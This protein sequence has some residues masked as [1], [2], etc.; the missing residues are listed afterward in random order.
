[1]AKLSWFLVPVTFMCWWKAL[2]LHKDA[3][4]TVTASESVSGKM[5]SFPKPRH[6]HSTDYENGQTTENLFYF[7]Q[8]SDIHTSVHNKYGGINNLRLFLNNTLS[9]ISPE[10]VL[11]TGDITDAKDA[12]KVGSQQLLEEWKM[13]YEV[14]DEFGILTREPKFWFDQRGNHDCFNVPSFHSDNNLFRKYSSVKSEQYSFMVEKTFG[15]YSFISVDACPISGPSRP[16]NFFGYLDRVD[17]DHL[18]QKVLQFSLQSNHTFVMAHYPIKMILT[19]VSS[20]GVSFPDLASHFSVFLS[21]H[22]HKLVAGLGNIMHAHHEEN[23]LEL[24]L[25]DLKTHGSYRII[26]VDHD[27][28]SF[29]DTSVLKKGSK[30]DLNTDPVVLITNP[31]DARYFITKH[32]PVS[33]IASSTHIRVLIFG[34]VQS[35]KCYIDGRLFSDTFQKATGFSQ[36]VPLYLI[37]WNPSFFKGEQHNLVIEA[38]DSQGKVGS[39]Q[40][41]FRTDGVLEPLLVGPGKYIILTR[42]EYW[43]K[44][45]FVVSYLIITLFLLLIPKLY[46]SVL[47]RSRRYHRWRLEYSKKLVDMDR[48]VAVQ[49]APKTTA[50]GRAKRLYQLFILKLRLVYLDFKYFVHA[51]IFR[52]VTLT[53]LPETFY[54]LYFYSL[55]IVVGPFFIGELIPDASV[56]KMH[57]PWY[58]K[59]GFFY[60]VGIYVE[61]NWL[62]L[63]DTWLFGLF[64]LLYMLG[65]LIVYLS[66]CITPPEQLYAPKI[67]A[68]QEANCFYIPPIHN[69]RKYPLHRRYFV[70]LIVGFFVF[71]QIINVFFLC[72]YY[73]PVAMTFSPGK[74]WMV[75]WSCYA[76]YKHRWSA[77]GLEIDLLI[78]DEDEEDGDWLRYLLRTQIEKVKRRRSLSSIRAQSEDEREKEFQERAQTTSFQMPST[79]RHHQ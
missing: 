55:Y 74:T 62:P 52:L 72:L 59:F 53:S 66:F 10:F 24:E 78:D 37:P 42:Y 46:S 20:T 64:E 31:K 38:T 73:G 11:A 3:T 45:V 29:I 9:K 43:F 2:R 63:L 36:E 34:V 51:T 77:Q 27:L 35:I 57:L 26:A 25:S 30:A 28:I 65:P 32:E 16:F 69:R 6:S 70:R 7:I 68:K 39:H 18:E 75:A 23:F 33:R 61:K 67:Q 47:H 54:P 22:L 58:E 14:L 44:L 4:A 76:L 41:I 15:K 8:I 49:L 60:L 40:V 21:G 17:M 19:G 56:E 79:R 12:W 13:Y 1:M 5:N 50:A 71:Y 48:P